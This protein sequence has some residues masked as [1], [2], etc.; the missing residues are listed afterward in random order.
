MDSMKFVA[1]DGAVTEVNFGEDG[2]MHVQNYV[3]A[4]EI[5]DQNTIIRNAHGKGIPSNKDE[6]R[7]VARIPLLAYMTQRQQGIISEHSGDHA[8]FRAWLNSRDNAAFRTSE[9]RV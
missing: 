9:G 8:R 6:W 4:Q 5:T 1:K 3:D 7:H 2:V